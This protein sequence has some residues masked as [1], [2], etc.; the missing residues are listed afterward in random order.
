MVGPP[1]QVAVPAPEPE[2]VRR[3]FE[4]ESAREGADRRVA[5]RAT[6]RRLGI[7]RRRVYRLLLVEDGD[8][9]GEDGGG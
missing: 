1:A 6:A 5:I 3:V 9:D 8:A 4:R 2:Q 7:S